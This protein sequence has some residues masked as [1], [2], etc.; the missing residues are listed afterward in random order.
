MES[1]ESEDGAA[2]S[3]FEDAGEL[4]KRNEFRPLT[5]ISEWVEPKSLTRRLTICVN[6]PSGIEVSG[7][8]VRV[9]EGGEFLEVTVVWP[10]PFLDVE[11]LHRKWI[12]L[13]KEDSEFMSGYHPEISR[14]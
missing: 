8:S 14:L 11:V 2:E 3:D 6:L 7:F 5:L 1:V 4:W 13:E 12:K 10:K 9:V